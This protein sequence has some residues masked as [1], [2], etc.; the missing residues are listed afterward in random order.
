MLFYLY[1]ELRDCCILTVDCVKIDSRFP[2]MP[3][4]VSD[5]IDITE[6]R[7]ESVTYDRVAMI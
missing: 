6:N 7:G 1:V 5:A 4:P 3:S 2:D